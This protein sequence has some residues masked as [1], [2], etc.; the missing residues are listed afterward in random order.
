V[1][2]SDIRTLNEIGGL[3]M[4]QLAG[5]FGVSHR[6]ATDWVVYDSVPP[7]HAAK[8]HHILDVVKSADRGTPEETCAALFDAQHGPSIYDRLADDTCIVTPAS[9]PVERILDRGP[10][11]SR[12]I[13]AELV[14]RDPELARDWTKLN[15]LLYYCQAWHLAW[16]GR[17][18]F[19]DAI[20]ARADGPYVTGVFRK[21]ISMRGRTPGVRFIGRRRRA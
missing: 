9:D 12:D 5:L 2:S 19:T 16:S 6:E 1:T 10:A 15:A 3:H 21:R 7:Q 11:R 20:L 4:G 14:R 8:L 18:L 13:A 17:P